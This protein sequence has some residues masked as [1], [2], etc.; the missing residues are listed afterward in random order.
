MM[1]LA[2]AAPH[3]RSGKSTITIGLIQALRQKK[4]LTVQPFKK[5]PDFIDPS[6]LSMAAARPC[7]NLDLYFVDAVK[8]QTL[9]TQGMAGADIGVVEGAMGFYDGLDL[10]GSDSTAAV[11]RAID[12]PVLLVVDATR[13]T[14]SAAALVK[15]FAEFESPGMISGVILNKVARPRHEDMLRNAIETYTGIP[16]LGALPK[17]SSLQIADRHLGLIPSSEMESTSE[18]INCLGETVSHGVDL[19]AVLRIAA[20][21]SEIAPHHNRISASHLSG[22]RAR[23][24]IIKDQVFSFYYPEN[25]EAL[26]EAGA[27][28]VII[29]SLECEELPT[30]DALYIGGGFPEVHAEKLAAN[31]LLHYA[32]RREV[33]A[34]LPIYAECGGLMFLARKL[35]Y[36]EQSFEMVGVLPCD[37][38][39]HKRVRGHGYTAFQVKRPNYLFAQGACLKGHEFHHSQICNA[40]TSLETVLDLK[41]GYGLDGH[42]EGILHHNVIATYNHLYA[43]SHPEWAQNLVS[44]A[45][46]GRHPGARE[47]YG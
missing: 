11:A 29:D 21:R 22:Y 33:A 43:P 37:T 6:W 13:M 34:G 12:T 23:I 28:L 46:R 9:F 39:M 10:Q 4:G 15:G 8:L 20:S 16:V 7:R 19:D 14:R 27:E 42:H 40:D 44:F 18:I 17:H 3:G 31:K 36:A 25:L 41:R 30:I 45:A 26:E 1:K 35:F 47:L 2:I 32:I 24:G 38:R 5:G